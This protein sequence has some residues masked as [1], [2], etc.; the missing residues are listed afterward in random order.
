[1]AST[2]ATIGRAISSSASAPASRC[3]TAAMRLPFPDR[4]LMVIFEPPPFSWRNRGAIAWYDDAFAGAGKVLIFP[5]AEQG[6]G[7]H[8]QLSQDEIVG[9]VRAAGVDA[10]SIDVANA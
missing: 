1:M 10:A 7:T 3:A 4:R 9:R 6:S 5:P 8:A 2:R